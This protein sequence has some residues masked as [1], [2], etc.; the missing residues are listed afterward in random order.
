M[1]V[2]SIEGVT[3]GYDKS[4]PLFD[5][6]SLHLQLGEIATVVGPSG[7]GKSTLLELVVG[8]LRPQ[9]GT[10]THASLSQV[11]Q[12]PYTSFHPS[13]SLRTQIADVAPLDELDFYM[14]ALGLDSSLID[15]KPHTLSGGQLQRFS[16]V[17]A[18]LMKPQLLLLDEPTSALDNVTQLEVMKLLMQF[19]DRLGILLITHDEALAAWCS[20]K[21]IRLA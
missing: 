3:F 14:E 6:L 16:M 7:S 5:N 4:K 1:E 11:F 17:R 18:L 2:L 21:V 15:A 19:L 10:I 9:K 8:R 12:D 13:Y 20:D